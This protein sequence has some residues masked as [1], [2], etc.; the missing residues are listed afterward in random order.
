MNWAPAMLI[1]VLA[2]AGLAAAAFAE[3]P[4][5]STSASQPRPLRDYQSACASCH[6][7]QGFAVRI[8]TD[9]VG[10]D[11][12]LISKRRDLSPDFIR[13]VVRG[14]LGAMP[15]M[16]RIEISDVELSAIVSELTRSSR[17]GARP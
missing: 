2:S 16:S 11:K 8:L 6:E 1:P 4:A 12:A 3:S 14:G 13:A 15:P 5:E 9:R 17:E 10:A 7:R